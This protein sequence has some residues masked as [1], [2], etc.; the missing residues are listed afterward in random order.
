MNIYDQQSCKWIDLNQYQYLRGAHNEETFLARGSKYW[1]RLPSV[2]N[3][4]LYTYSVNT[5][6]TQIYYTS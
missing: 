4:S 6:I 2:L 3:T 5:A 1:A